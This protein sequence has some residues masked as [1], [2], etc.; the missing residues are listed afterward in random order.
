MM[1]Y[2]EPSLLLGLVALAWFA[3]FA[4]DKFRTRGLDHTIEAA[5][6]RHNLDHPNDQ[7]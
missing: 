2:N 7:I 5:R 4:W 3:K 6:R 1:E